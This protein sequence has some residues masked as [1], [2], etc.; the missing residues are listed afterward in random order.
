MYRVSREKIV[1]PINIWINI[2]NFYHFLQ[3]TVA[4]TELITI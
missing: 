4:K 2:L 1:H 3:F